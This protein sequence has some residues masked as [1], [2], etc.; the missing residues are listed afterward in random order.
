MAEI[1]L[2]DSPRPNR[3]VGEDRRES[4][5]SGVAAGKYRSQFAMDQCDERLFGLLSRAGIGGATDKSSEQAMAFGC[6]AREKR[7]V[8]DGSKDRKAGRTWDKET[9]TIGCAAEIGDAVAERNDGHG[10]IFE[11]AELGFKK[12]IERSEQI[13]GDGCGDGEDEALG[14]AEFAALRSA[15]G[16]AE[17][18]GV[19]FMAAIERL[20]GSGFD[21]E[22]EGVAEYC[23]E[24]AHESFI[25]LAEGLHGAFFARPDGIGRVRCFF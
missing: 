6:A 10:R 19:G 3:D 4:G 9:E 24:R 14:L 18:R 13:C 15:Q 23:G 20:D 8:P 16:D 2:R 12:R 11:S 1:V 21:V 25:A 22:P 5:C 7:R 17:A